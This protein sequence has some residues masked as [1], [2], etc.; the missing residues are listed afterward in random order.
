MEFAVPCH[1]TCSHICVI[2]HPFPMTA[3]PI[4]A[5]F[6]LGEAV[7]KAG[8]TAMIGCV[9]LFCLCNMDRLSEVHHRV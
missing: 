5:R 9:A 2:P 8:S 4:S 6:P 7:W 3:G 1:V